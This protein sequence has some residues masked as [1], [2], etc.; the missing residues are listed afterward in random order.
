MSFGLSWIFPESEPWDFSQSTS[1]CLESVRSLE[2]DEID[3]RDLSAFMV[4]HENGPIASSPSVFIIWG[5]KDGKYR[6][7]CEVARKEIINLTVDGENLTGLVRR[8][9]RK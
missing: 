7:R 1:L 9:E 4:G 6:V 5:E 8:E 2:L 3:S